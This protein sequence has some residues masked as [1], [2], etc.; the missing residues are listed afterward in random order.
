[1]AVF[2]GYLNSCISKEKA[3]PLTAV[4]IKNAKSK[5]N[6]TR[7]RIQTGFICLS[8]QQA[9]SIGILIIDMIGSAKHLH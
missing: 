4:Q 3:M 7:F 2:K 9:G 1:M 6:N 8:L 5:K